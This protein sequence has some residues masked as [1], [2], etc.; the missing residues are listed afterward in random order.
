MFLCKNRT[1]PFSMKTQ[2]AHKIRHR[3]IKPS[4]AC[5][6]KSMELMN[7]MKQKDE[8]LDHIVHA[9]TAGQ[10]LL[11]RARSPALHFLT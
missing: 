6:M 7:L 4:R 1:S 10:G 5:P 2:A 9:T 11:S 8:M 3:G